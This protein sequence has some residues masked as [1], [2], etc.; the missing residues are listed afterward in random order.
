MENEEIFTAVA[1]LLI[2]GT[3]VLVWT[4]WTQTAESGRCSSTARHEE[5]VGSPE[6]R[7]YDPDTAAFSRE[8]GT[9]PD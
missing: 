3:A 8:A 5:L 7:L 9:I 1:L 2:A 4:R 6:R